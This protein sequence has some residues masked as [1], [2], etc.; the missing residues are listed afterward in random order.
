[1]DLPW[2]DFINSFWRDWRGSGRSEDR[3]DREDWLRAFLETWDLPAADPPTTQE[4]RALKEFRTLLLG[5]A[6]RAAAG[7]GLDDAGLR[8]LNRVMR[9]G[10]VIRELAAVDEAYALQERPVGRDWRQ[11]MAEVAGSF[12][13]TLAEGDPG[14]VRMCANRDCRWVFYDDTRNRSKRFCDDRA[15]GNLV[16]VRRFRA[17]QKA[18]GHGEVPSG[19]TEA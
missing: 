4:R 17:R 3:L 15:C 2:T 8:E 9:E 13:V 11:V 12:A 7:Q 18:H 1:M 5:L 19:P 6:E 16:R 14:R 10:P